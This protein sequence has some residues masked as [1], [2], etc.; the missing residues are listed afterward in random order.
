MLVQYSLYPRTRNA[1]KGLNSPAQGSALGYDLEKNNNPERVAFWCASGFS[2]NEFNPYRVD[3]EGIAR[4]PGQCPG[5]ENSTP[6]GLF[7]IFCTAVI[8]NNLSYYRGQG[9]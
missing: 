9:K 5:L 1:L 6:V 4:N 7:L 8:Q 3:F 2:E